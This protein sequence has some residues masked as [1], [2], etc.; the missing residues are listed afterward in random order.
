[1]SKTK[2]K[3]HIL[4]SGVPLEHD[5]KLVLKDLAIVAPKEY[6]YIKMNEYGIPTTFSI[7][8]YCSKIY[9]DMGLWLDL[10]IECKYK[11]DSIKWLF[12]SDFFDTLFKSGIPRDAF[13]FLDQLVDDRKINNEYLNS[14]SNKYD[15][16]S[17][18]IELL[19]KKYNPAAIRE[20]IYQLR[21]GIVDL[22]SSQIHQQFND[23]QQ[24][25]SA[26]WI[27]VVI[28]I[29]VTTAELWVTKPE[30]SMEKIRGVEHFE[31]LAE[32]TDFLFLR[33]EPTNYLT[34]FSRDRLL[35]SF[36]HEQ[37]SILDKMFSKTKYKSY[38][39]FVKFFSYHY[40]VLFLIVQFPYFRQIVSQLFSFFES[41]SLYL[42]EI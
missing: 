38:H 22:V 24:K 7:D 1:M 4:K 21:F 14:F 5:T 16:A 31:D 25:K 26:K 9:K 36:N 11:H 27:N 35:N 2:W 8:I 19:D 13:I 37:I 20:G 28:P 10:L 3:N 32:K 12:I 18:G 34:S 17:R 29:I 23:I 33:E 39:T 40:P 30:F 42:K 6:E 15:L 41:S